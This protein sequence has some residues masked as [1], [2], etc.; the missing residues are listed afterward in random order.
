MSKSHGVPLSLTDS[1]LARWRRHVLVTATCWVWMGALGGRDGYGR[2]AL[3]EHGRQ[4]TVTPHQVAATVAWG[5]VAAGATIL[6]DCELRVC[7]S[8]ADGHVRVSTQAENMQQAAARGR[9]RG[10]RFGNVDV[11]GSGGASRA[12]QEALRASPDRTAEGL[13]LALRDALAAGD[14]LRGNLVLFD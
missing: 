6:H 5:P 13:A 11:R 8:T 10:P 4:R 12:V 1:D 2:F 14:P 9:A 7:V 3:R